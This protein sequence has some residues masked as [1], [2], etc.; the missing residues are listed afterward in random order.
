MDILNSIMAEA[1]AYFW[2]MNSRL[3]LFYLAFTVI[4]AYVI[5][6]VRGRPETFSFWTDHHCQLARLF[7]GPFVRA[8]CAAR[9]YMEPERNC[10]RDHDPD[11]GFL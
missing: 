10:D 6:H 8:I 2:D 3:A 4:L 1:T 5:W 9:F 7:C 11:I